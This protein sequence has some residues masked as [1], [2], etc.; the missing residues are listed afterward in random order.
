MGIK[1]SV[2]DMPIQKGVCLV[3]GFLPIKGGGQLWV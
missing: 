2:A 1:C 3:C